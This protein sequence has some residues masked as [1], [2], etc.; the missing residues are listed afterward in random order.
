MVLEFCD[1]IGILFLCAT[2][3]EVVVAILIV[4][5]RSHVQLNALTDTSYM[6]VFRSLE[7][8]Y[9]HLCSPFSHV[10]EFI[11]FSKSSF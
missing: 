9:Q 7:H 2:G 6:W 10:T 1:S 11:N 3:N 8:S 4:S 5:N